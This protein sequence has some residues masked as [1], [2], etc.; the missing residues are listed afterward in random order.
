MHRVTTEERRARL[1]RRHL[2]DPEARVTSV[3]AVA[4]A[5][6]A[7]HSTDAAT[8]FLS[9]RARTERLDPPAIEQELYDDRTVVRMHGMRRTLFVVPREAR[10]LVQAACADD[11]ADRERER[12]LGWLAEAPDIDDPPAW[13][14]EAE[15]AALAAVAA[16]DGAATAEL[17]RRVPLLATKI[18]VGAG[19][20]TVQQRIGSRVLM[21]L[22]AQGRLVRGPPRG[23]W[24]SG[25]YRWVT[26]RAWLGDEQERPSRGEA[27]A[28]LVRRWLRANG[29]G[30]ELD[31]RWW[32]GLTARAIR[33]ALAAVDA[34]PVEL[35]GAGGFL[36]ADDLEPVERRE[37]SAAFLPTLD[38]TTMGWKERE[39]YLGPHGPLLFDRNGNAGPTVWWEGRVVGGWSQRGDGEIVYRLL[40]DVGSDALRAVEQEAA[41]LAAWLGDVRLSPGF[42]PPFQRAL[43]A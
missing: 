9:I 41:R 7:L 38:S 3:A 23:T 10:P 1:V 16:S 11:I 42:L 26:T 19:R 33:E 14:F 22:A 2:L 25:Q 34:V 31:L 36:L 18:E 37:P 21:L 13:L 6:V 20:W 40:E 24:I 12:V 30:T 4:E 28:A 17:V 43:S 32:T 5:L 39:W 27:R 8:V 35:D 29:P 15:R